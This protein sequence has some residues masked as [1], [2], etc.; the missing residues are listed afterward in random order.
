M[1]K[2]YARLVC[3]ILFLFGF[4]LIS[5]AWAEPLAG[6][7]GCEDRLLFLKEP[8]LKG[9]DVEVLQQRLK[10]LGFY[11]GK[12]SGSFDAATAQAVKRFQTERNLT[13][14]GLVGPATWES[15]AQGA[16]LETVSQPLPPPDGFVSIEIN[17]ENRNLTVYSDGEP[18]YTFTTAIG[19]S[20]TPS[21][22]GEW[23]VVSKDLNWGGGFGTRWMGLNVPWGNY[24]IHGT[25]KPY[26][27]GSAASHGCF[28]MHN[29]E[30]EQLYPWVKVGTPVTVIGSDAKISAARTLKPLTIGP[31]VVTVQKRLRER[32]FYLF[33]PADGRYGTLSSIATSYFE[34]ANG[35]EVT[36]EVDKTVYHYLGF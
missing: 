28:R 13:P 20:K 32:G 26:T 22:V 27:I 3:L 15:L 8:P 5:P 6:G 16:E 1:A 18:Y 29:R 36:G 25:N 17:L 10:T 4:G 30:V 33:A 31:D 11:E 23:K 24:G 35:L 14:N 2:I 12:V 19:K 21:P 34:A 7:C 9:D